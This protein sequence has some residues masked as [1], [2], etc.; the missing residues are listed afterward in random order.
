MKKTRIMAKEKAK[1][2]KKSEKIT[3]DEMVTHFNNL[4]EAARDSRNTL[5]WDWYIRKLF[6]SGQQFLKWNR[7]TKQVE[8]PPLPEQEV[9]VTVNK[10]YT[11]LRAVRSYVTKFQPKWEV[12]AEDVSDDGMEAAKR[13]DD[14]LDYVYI[15]HNMKRKIKELVQNGLI[16]SVG[17]W[18][19]GWDEQADDNEGDIFIRS[20][21]P[22][23]LYIDPAATTLHDASYVIKTVRK[24]IQDL[25]ANPIYSNLDNIKGDNKLAASE[26]K[27]RFIRGEQGE[28]KELDN[29]LAT[30]ILKEIYVREPQ[31]DGTSKIKRAA[32]I[33]NTLV[34]PEETTE[35][36][37]FPFVMYQADTDPLEIYGDGWVKN[38]IPVQRVINKLEG[39]ILGYNDIF[40]KGKY[41][42]DK[43]SGVRVINNRHGQ[44]IEKKRGTSVDPI[45]LQGL[46]PTVR[47]QV[48]NFNLY[49]ED[50]GGAHDASLGRVPQG[51]KAGVA[52]EALQ[53]GDANNLNE[54]RDNLEDA[55][56]E[57]ANLVFWN[58]ATYRKTTKLV[59][60]KR[61]EEKDTFFNV[62]GE[63]ADNKPKKVGKIPVYE[64]KK[65]NDVRVY[66]GSWLA[67]NKEA[68][69]EKLLQLAEAKIIDRATLLKYFNFPNVQE[70]VDKVRAEQG[71]DA[72]PGEGVAQETPPP[73]GGQVPQAPQGPPIGGE[74][75][76]PV[77]NDV[78]NQAIQGGGG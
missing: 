21:D 51:A 60:P 9:R 28:N 18:E 23:D 59:R 7:R 55:L 33:D 17:F 61:E 14:M 26:L 52:I 63:N 22:F 6:V 53:A 70:I 42:V 1:T 45:P 27:A 3:H 74:Q 32:F 40:A 69:L 68:E 19:I 12:M 5:D 34:R 41:V 73:N 25:K 48:N 30:V 46:P 15:V 78:L 38:L 10:I 8:S 44:I 67:Y 77:P 50:I 39:L 35:M 11:T 37:R 76:Q 75:Q 4:W 2:A 20:I 24:T 58:F 13:K 57:A 62:I 54:L 66:I 36:D 64:I 16:Y 43:D 49:I 56:I 47:D 65:N 31:E 29:D 72:P 71:I